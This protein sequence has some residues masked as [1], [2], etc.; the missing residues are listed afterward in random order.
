L[1]L[2]DES[3]GQHSRGLILMLGWCQVLCFSPFQVVFVGWADTAMHMCVLE[4]SQTAYYT[5]IRGLLCQ[6]LQN[7]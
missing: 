4:W 6:G 7:V 1:L 3:T 5:V 2:C